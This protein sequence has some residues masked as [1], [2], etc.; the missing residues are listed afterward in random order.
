MVLLRPI[1]GLLKI[2]QLL[3]SN[4]RIL[5]ILRT[6]EVIEEEIEDEVVEEG[7]DAEVVKT[8]EEDPLIFVIL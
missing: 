5:L 3:A 8:M 6:V 1:L 7:V 2:N 4:H